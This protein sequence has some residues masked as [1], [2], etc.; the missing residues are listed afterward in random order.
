VDFEREY[1]FHLGYAGMKKAPSLKPLGLVVAFVG[2]T[3]FLGPI[4]S[5]GLAVVVLWIH[6]RRTG[7][8]IS[9]MLNWYHGVLFDYLAYPDNR[10][11]APG[12]TRAVWIAEE[13]IW[14]R[15]WHVTALL[16]P[17]YMG[18]AANLVVWSTFNEGAGALL[19][20]IM[21][22]MPW[23][24][25][26]AVLASPIYELLANLEDVL[27]SRSGEWDE[28]V[29][30]LRTSTFEYEGAR[31]AEHLFLGWLLPSCEQAAHPF[32]KIAPTDLPCRTPALN[33][34][35]Q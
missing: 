13:S 25:L 6:L 27:P 29:N 26:C 23:L 34:S 18:I 11:T 5:Y 19:A 1:Q 28:A 14:L 10:Y 32:R 30:R 33:N 20:V 7:Q 8:A 22:P 12:G 9:Q 16:V 17:L 35:A 31:L 4:G 2:C 15:L 24:A 3:A 21:M